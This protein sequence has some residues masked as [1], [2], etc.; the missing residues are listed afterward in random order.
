MMALFG[1]DSTPIEACRDALSAAVNTL[2]ASENVSRILTQHID[3]PIK[4]G[5]GIHIG[6][7]V[8]GRIGKTIDQVGPSR[9]TAIGDSVNIAARLESANKELNSVVVISKAVADIAEL[10]GNMK[11]GQ[12]SKITVHNISKPIEV[13]SI[14]DPKNLEIAISQCGGN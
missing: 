7:A 3:E 11:L 6:T 8:V 2:K 4:I 1:L 10:P 14:C 13:I 9:L 5:I 12:N